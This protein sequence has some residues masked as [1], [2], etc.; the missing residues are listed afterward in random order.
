MRAPLREGREELFR[1]FCATGSG[2]KGKNR[3]GMGRV[4]KQ[5][6]LRRRKEGDRQREW[7][8]GSDLL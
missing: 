1:R 2:K 6:Q 5:P 4:E 3:K 8:G 7:K